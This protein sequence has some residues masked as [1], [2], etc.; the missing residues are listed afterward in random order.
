MTRSLFSNLWKVTCAVLGLASASLFAADSAITPATI[1]F[2]LS[3][4]A[5]LT[6]SEVKTIL[7]SSLVAREW[8]VKENSDERV[9]GYLNHRG[10]E[11]T[12]TLVYSG[13]QVTATCEG[14][15]V[16]KQGKRLKPEHPTRWMTNIKKDIGERLAK[17]ASLK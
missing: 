14:W 16:D 1:T 2:T 15:S 12:L 5:K 9:I 3:V 10:T 17:T 7:V 8:G 13:T 6:A 4:P 11:A